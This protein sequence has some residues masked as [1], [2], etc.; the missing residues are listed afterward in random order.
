MY[1][2][3]VLNMLLRHGPLLTKQI[4]KIMSLA[5]RRTDVFKPEILEW[6]K[7]Q[8]LI[9]ST[10]IWWNK[11]WYITRKGRLWLQDFGK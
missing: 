5:L 8:D 3:L 6:L 2:Q 7:K 9:G 4:R 10:G 1:K 11:R